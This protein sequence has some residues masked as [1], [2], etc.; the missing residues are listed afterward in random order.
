M[1]AKR[2]SELVLLCHPLPISS[3]SVD[4]MFGEA[5]IDATATVTTTG[6]TGVEMASTWRVSD[7]SIRLVVPKF[8]VGGSAVA[9]ATWTERV[10]ALPS[11]R[12]PSEST[13][14]AS[15]RAIPSGPSPGWRS[16]P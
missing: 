14:R 8:T 16:Y 13:G 2:T 12:W 10:I 9:P 5:G 1:A 15:P 11:D 3:V 4:F 6:Q 7:T